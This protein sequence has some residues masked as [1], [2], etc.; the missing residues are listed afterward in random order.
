MKASENQVYMRYS[1]K[2]RRLIVFFLLAGVIIGGAMNSPL[3]AGIGDDL[4]EMYLLSDLSGR[5]DYVGFKRNVDTKDPDWPL[6]VISDGYKMVRVY[7]NL[8]GV[9]LVEWVWQMTIKNTVAR[10]VR[11]TLEYKLLD[12]DLFFVASS[13]APARTIFPGQTVT[14]EKKDILPHEKIKKVEN[15]NW[16]IQLQ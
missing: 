4:K 8:P 5:G 6:E 15:S 13:L 16:Y 12:R 10:E 11:F 2:S 3:H 9:Y 7:Q 1:P 14:V